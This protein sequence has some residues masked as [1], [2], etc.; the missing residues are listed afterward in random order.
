MVIYHLLFDLPAAV[1]TVSAPLA[2]EVL[3]TATELPPPPAYD[4]PAA[5]ASGA[6]GAK[7]RTGG[8]QPSTGEK[9]VPKWLKVGSTLCPL[10]CAKILKFSDALVREVN[11]RERA[12]YFV[13]EKV[14]DLLI[15]TGIGPEAALLALTRCQT[16]M[17]MFCVAG[18]TLLNRL[19]QAQ[20]C[21]F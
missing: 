8:F 5:A 9:K 2:P 13:L 12:D 21:S 19:L 7:P 14:Y 20:Y 1:P 15:F 11:E 3:A 16:T 4:A 10:F 17:A 6:S 18:R